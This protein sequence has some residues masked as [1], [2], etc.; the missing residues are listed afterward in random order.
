MSS[1][2]GGSG[3][4]QSSVRT[5]F[6]VSDGGN[7]KLPNGVQ[8]DVTTPEGMAAAKAQLSASQLSELEKSMA[9]SGFVLK[10]GTF[11]P[12]D[13]YE[14]RR[15]VSAQAGPT[16]TTEGL[17][18]SDT[19]LINNVFVANGVAS[20]YNANTTEKLYAQIGNTPS[21]Q[22]AVAAGKAAFANPTA[23][24]QAEFIAKMKALKA[25]FPNGN[26]M[27][28]LFLVFRESIKETNEDKK[29]FL[30]KL[31]EYNKMAEDVSAYLSDLVKES[32]RLSEASAG[33]KYPEKVTIQVQ[34]KSFDLSTLGTDGNLKTTSTGTKTLDRAGLNDTIKDVESMQETI[35]NKRQ[36]ASTA[37][38]NF[39]Q[40]ANQL[41]N[42]MS[43]VLKAIGEMRQGTARNMM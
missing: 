13:N 35:R 22:G 16:A 15:D 20:P 9:H 26:I 29:Y 36:M 37:F 40:K 1:A 18:P 7:V 42:L 32:Q 28:I 19:E 25:E 41:Y 24:N 17:S 8:A 14:L 5:T 33:Q 27:E 11:V 12:K 38:Q 23:A 31:E 10:E 3:I 43:S 34:V 4:G 6:T 21:F 30:I 2:G 39:D